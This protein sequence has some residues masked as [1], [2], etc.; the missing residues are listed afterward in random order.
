MGAGIF[1]HDQRAEG[2][3][4]VWKRSFLAVRRQGPLFSGPV[5]GN[6]RRSSMLIIFTFWYKGA[7][8]VL[9]SVS[10]L[11]GV[12]TYSH[13]HAHRH[14]TQS[15]HPS[16]VPG[17]VFLR[18]KVLDVRIDRLTAEYSINR[19][20]QPVSTHTQPGRQQ[21]IATASQPPSCSSANT[22]SCHMCACVCA[23]RCASA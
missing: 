4:T 11:S 2:K 13:A 21:P 17:A 1:R 15:P 19:I 8:G 22:Y 12:H 7:N 10:C 5:L 3:V 14:G 16:P 23:C 18:V 20:F 9:F 6:E